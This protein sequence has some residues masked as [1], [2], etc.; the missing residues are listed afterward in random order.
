VPVDTISRER[1]VWAFSIVMK[2]LKR[3]VLTSEHISQVE[4]QDIISSLDGAHRVLQKAERAERR[5]IVKSDD[6]FDDWMNE[7]NERRIESGRKPK[8]KREILRAIIDAML[9][10]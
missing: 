9:G 2:H 8:G 3:Y 10:K 1:V 6:N 4:K 7:Y 5:L